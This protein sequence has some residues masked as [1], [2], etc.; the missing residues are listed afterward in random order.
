M[1]ENQKKSSPV[2]AAVA[3]ELL[4][5]DVPALLCRAN[6]L[7]LVMHRC[8]AVQFATIW[9]RLTSQVC[10]KAKTEVSLRVRESH[11]KERNNNKSFSHS[12]YSASFLRYTSSFI[13]SGCCRGASSVGS[14]TNPNVTTLIAPQI[15]IFSSLLRSTIYV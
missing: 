12:M 2:I 13:S 1:S 4:L 7:H 3:Q 10:L 9:V 8:A 11:T 14:P 6:I 5:N 15:F